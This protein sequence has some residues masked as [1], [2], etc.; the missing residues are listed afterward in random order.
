VTSVYTINRTEKPYRRTIFWTVQKSLYQCLKTPHC[1]I[2]GNTLMSHRKNTNS[3]LKGVGMQKF[4]I[5]HPYLL[6]LIPILF[7]AFPLSNPGIILT[8]DFPVLDTSSYASGKLSVWTEKGSVPALET[9]SRFPIIGAW[10]ILSL[11]GVSTELTSKLMVV[12]GYLLASFTFYLSFLLLFKNRVVAD[13]SGS[14]TRMK[15]AAIIGALFFA[16]NPW[17]FERIP[18]WYLWIG[19]AVLPLFFITVVLAFREPKK[20]G[21]IIS[22]IFLWSFASTTPHMT[23]FYGIIFVSIFISFVLG[24]IAAIRFRRRQ[25]EQIY[26]A[27]NAKRSTIQLLIPFLSIFFLYILVNAY[28]IYPYVMST[29]VRSISP[30]YLVTEENLELLS[31]ESNFLNTFRLVAN[32]QEQP[33]DIPEEGSSLYYVW[34]IV[35]FALPIFGFSAIAISRKFVRY[36]SAFF[37]SLVIGIIIAMGTQSPIDYFK[38][39]IENPTLSKYA[40]LVRDPD[41]L[42]FVIAFTSSFLIGISSHRILELIAEKTEEG[43]KPRPKLRELV[44]R[45]H[46]YGRVF[47]STFFLCLLVGSMCIYIYPVYIFNMFGELRPVAL[48]GEFDNLNSYLSSVDARKVYFIPYPLDETYW[49]KNNRVGNIYQTHSVLPSIESSGSISMAGMGSTNYY[50]YLTRSV[51]ENR[52]KNIANFIH[53]LGTSYLIFHNDTWDK[54]SGTADK[55]NLELLERLNSLEGL[56]NVHNVGFYNI[57][58]VD[59]KFDDSVSIPGQFNIYGNDVAVLGGL[60]AMESLNGLYPSFNSSDT[61]LYFFDQGEDTGEPERVKNSEYILF[62]NSP[63]YYDLLF[64]LVNKSHIFTLFDTLINYEPKK[65]WSK[66]STMDPDSGYFHPYLEHLGIDN[67][68]FDH[69]RGLAITQAMGTNLTMSF[70]VTQSGQYDLFMRYLESRKGGALKIYLD[71]NFVGNINSLDKKSDSFIWQEVRSDNSTSVFLKKGKHILTIE[72]VVGFNAINLVGVLPINTISNLEHEVS[73]MVNRTKEIYFIEAETG[74]KNNKGRSIQGNSSSHPPSLIHISDDDNNMSEFAPPQVSGADSNL[75]TTLTG[76]FRI[77]QNADLLSLYFLTHTKD[78]YYNQSYNTPENLTEI[79]ENPNYSIKSLRVYPAH[80]SYDIYSSN[81]ERKNQSVPLATLRKPVWIADNEDTL[82]AIWDAR[83]PISGNSSLRVNIGQ[84]NFSEWSMIS[85]D[86]FPIDD[87]SYYGFNLDISARN[88]DQLHS[89]IIFF[90]ESRERISHDFVSHGRDG[91]FEDVYSA[92]IVPPFGAKYLRFEILTRPAAADNTSYYLIDDMKFEEYTVMEGSFEEGD[93][94]SSHAL[95]SSPLTALRMY[96]IMKLIYDD[97]GSDKNQDLKM[98][99]NDTQ[100]SSSRGGKHD[101]TLKLSRDLGSPSM[102]IQKTR[103]IPV[104]E[105]NLYN[106][107][108]SFDESYRPGTTANPENHK[109]YKG[110]HDTPTVIAYFSNSS[111]VVDNSTKY[112]NDANNGNVLS[113]SPGAEIYTDFNIVK[114]SEYA[115]ALRANTC[116]SCTFLSIAIENKETNKIIKTEYISLNDTNDHIVD[117]RERI[118]SERMRWLYLNESTYLNTGSYEMRIHSDSNAAN[119]IDLDSVIIYSNNPVDSNENTKAHEKFDKFLGS[120]REPL[121]A[122]LDG[123]RKISPAEYE[124]SIKNATRPYMLSLAESYDPLWIARDVEQNRRGNGNLDDQIFQ[125]RSIPLYSIVNGF[126]INKTGDYTLRIEYQPQ[127]WFMQGAII[128]IISTISIFLAYVIFRYL[129]KIIKFL[130]FVSLYMQK[131]VG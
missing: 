41:K 12:L 22:S 74:F 80:E 118:N 123:Q 10:Y 17:S 55:Q 131:K 39:I 128:S 62:G 49:S 108:V 14:Y 38:P 83:Y 95:L 61:S 34:Y 76:Q 27:D 67:W 19:Y 122:Y 116:D 125:T 52:S 65:Q 113:L 75:N 112:G 23:V 36:S 54:G 117:E 124:I 99:M 70:D 88:V 86:L 25:P 5:K 68:Q 32:W 56:R 79:H 53:P 44:R 11:V 109:M 89:K 84:G 121:P 111:D 3:L 20:L 21:Y 8:A 106:Y 71:N 93:V 40:W 73:S 4:V 24:N 47:V 26:A 45:G 96:E 130:N 91:T 103:P 90:N 129:D 57:F 60:E 120:K 107:T 72:N 43:N 15:I 69:G 127:E 18:H 58:K 16:Y 48:P 30:N 59:S 92:S 7:I 77:P 13:S 46:G 9:I 28:W 78:N 2:Y 102:I 85:T 87:R 64:S 100:I 82:S 105:N 50:N 114:P 37:C 97:V 1:L 115:I 126:Y 35:S 33:F 42:S 81:F 98:E 104:K 66:A 31:R 119:Y 51:I 101:A 110:S 94:E 63:S 29:Q 6:M